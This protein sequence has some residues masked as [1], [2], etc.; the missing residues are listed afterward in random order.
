[1]LINRINSGELEHTG[2]VLLQRE[3]Y[4]SAFHLRIKLD[5]NSPFRTNLSV[6]LMYH[7]SESQSQRNADNDTQGERTR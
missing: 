4:L 5:L 2:L 6:E 3:A 7:G 1:M